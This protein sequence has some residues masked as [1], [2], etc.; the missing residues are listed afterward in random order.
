MDSVDTTIVSAVA[1][2][3]TFKA[4]WDQLHT[5]IA[6]KLQTRIFI[7]LYQ[8]NQVNKDHKLIVEYMRDIRSLFDKLA[9]NGSP[10]NNEELK[11]KILSVHGPEFYEISEAIQARDSPISY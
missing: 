9:T 1:S 3:L 7:L 2:I 11:V 6:N 5:L 10:V 4:M 8:L